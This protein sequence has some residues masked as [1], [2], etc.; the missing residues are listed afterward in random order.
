MSKLLGS[1][2]CVVCV[3]LCLYVRVNALWQVVCVITV[4]CGAALFVAQSVLVPTQ[5]VFISTQAL[6]QPPEGLFRLTL[7]IF[8]GAAAQCADPRATL[9][10]AA[11]AQHWATTA[12]GSAARGPSS[13]AVYVPTEGVCRVTWSCEACTLRSATTE[14]QF[15]SAS[16]A[17]ASFVRF[18]METPALV[19][20]LT[21]TSPIPDTYA[22]TGYVF[23]AQTVQ[24]STSF[25]LQGARESVVNLLLTECVDIGLRASDRVLVCRWCVYC[26]LHSWWLKVKCMI[27]VVVSTE[28]ECTAH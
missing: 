17:W 7:E 9:Q 14:L 25:V 4:A 23:P 28:F 2:F 6:P 21:R 12:D 10:A 11:F 27:V 22:T 16:P 24:S 26:D 3:C 15:Q 13:G 18:T 1:V 20:V 5:T 19:S 8:G